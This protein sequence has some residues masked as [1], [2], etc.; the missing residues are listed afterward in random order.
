LCFYDRAWGAILT[1]PL[2]ANFDPQGRSCL[3]VKFA[4]RPS[5]LLN[6]RE[7]SPLGDKFHPW[8]PSSPLGDKFNPW[9]PSSPLGAKLRMA[10]CPRSCHVLL[11]KSSPYY[12]QLKDK[13]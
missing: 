6:R 2:G 5:N 7:C 10:L 8:R 4:A 13:F 3:P 11:W 1:S 12:S 9:G